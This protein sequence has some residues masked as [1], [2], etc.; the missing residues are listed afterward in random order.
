MG[1]GKGQGC[2][3]PMTGE[4]YTDNRRKDLERKRRNNY[5]I[6]SVID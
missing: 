2:I 3:G 4:E 5:S 6:K 1:F